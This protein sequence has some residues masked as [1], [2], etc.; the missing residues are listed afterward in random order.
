MN[1]KYLTLEQN[2]CSARIFLNIFGLTLEDNVQVNE[3]S[4]LKIFD[5][6]KKVVGELHFDNGHV[7]LSASYNDAFLEA[8]YDMA[9]LNGFV[10]YECGN[11]LFGQW[12]S[13]IKF[14]LKRNV[15]PNFSGEVLITCSADSEFGVNCLCHP[16]MECEVPNSGKVTVKIQ[17]DG[18]VF[19]AL[20]IS[21]DYL[22]TI[23]VR[24][25]NS[26]AGFLIHDIKKGEYDDKLGEY[27]YRKYAGIFSGGEDKEGKNKLHVF[28]SENEGK[29]DL[30]YRN[31]FPLKIGEDN[32][33]ELLLQKGRLMRELDSDMYDKIKRLRELFKV[34]NISVLDNLVSVCYDSFSDEA[35]EALMG[36]KREKMFYQDGTDTL[37]NSYFG[38]G[39]RNTLFPIKIQQRLIREK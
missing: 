16:L 3:F 10:D 34:G 35:I 24:P 38:I 1:G 33:R 15:A 36:L 17:R 39:R 19:E 7:I 27:P 28:L 5:K 14:N 20:I 9:I 29:K 31:E 8:S 13:A 37:I 26:L 30:V 4:K 23:E 18:S 12:N 22:E 2:L 6:Y 25:W 11:A 32:S 21:G